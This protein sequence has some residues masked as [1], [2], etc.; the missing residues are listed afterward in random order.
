MSSKKEEIM[1]EW[2]ILMQHQRESDWIWGTK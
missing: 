2:E 1:V